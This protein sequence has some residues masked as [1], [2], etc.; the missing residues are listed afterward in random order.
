MCA[1][2]ARHLLVV[3]QS[4]TGG[5][6]MLADAAI[7]GATSDD[8]DDVDVR[9]RCA[10]D[11]V[12]DDVR[13][14]DGILMG[15]PENFGYMSGALKDFF[16]RIYYEVLDETRGLPYALFVKGAHDGEGA[17][18]SVERVATGLGWKPAL[19]PVIV[20]GDPDDAARARC[21]ELGL[22]FAAGV[23]AGVF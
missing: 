19:E 6:Q 21:R 4:R 7:G 2:V 8:I 18:R 1:A 5:T 23:E 3:Y 14:S 9:V 10:F 11:A 20:V 22:T 16:E 17:V 13:W 12:A 15:T